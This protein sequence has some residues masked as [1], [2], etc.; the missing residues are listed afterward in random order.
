MK[1]PPY[2]DARFTQIVDELI[3]EVSRANRD[4]LLRAIRD[5]IEDW[6]G[7]SDVH[8]AI[9]TAIDDWRAG[10]PE[11]AESL[12]DAL[13]AAALIEEGLDGRHAG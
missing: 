6:D 2:L 4:A 13:L 3:P 10:D 9:G 12:D 5:A 11:P 8:A 1:I 7:T